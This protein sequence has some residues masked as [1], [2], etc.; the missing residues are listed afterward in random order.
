MTTNGTI[1]FRSNSFDLFR[2]AAGAKRWTRDI[3]SVGRN[4]LDATTCGQDSD[5]TRDQWAEEVSW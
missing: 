5:F 4:A 3:N 1:G 2:R